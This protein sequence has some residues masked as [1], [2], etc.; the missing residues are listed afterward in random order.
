MKS[1]AGRHP[2]PDFLTLKSERNQSSKQ[3]GGGE[4][5]K[6]SFPPL[7]HR[8]DLSFQHIDYEQDISLTYELTSQMGHQLGLPDHNHP[9]S[10]KLH[11]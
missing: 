3:D 2:Q 10:P 4:I 8:C 7:F 11:K 9:H 6:L 5:T 1:K